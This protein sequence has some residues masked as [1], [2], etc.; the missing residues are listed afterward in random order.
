M[1]DPTGEKV[2]EAFRHIGVQ[3][4]GARTEDNLRVARQ[5][6]RRRSR[7]G[8]AAS[9]LVLG[10]GI[11]M[12]VSYRLWPGGREVGKTPTVVQDPLGH[13]LR[14]SDGSS[15]RMLGDHSQI[16]VVAVTAKAND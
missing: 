7:T 1:L 4:D 10:L 15:A 5:R 11:A 12:G 16:E 3:W 8:M 13:G 6:I 9:A 2:E 14:F